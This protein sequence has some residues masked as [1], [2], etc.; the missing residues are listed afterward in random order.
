MRGRENPRRFESLEQEIGN[1]PVS[2][3]DPFSFLLVLLFVEAENR[4]YVY[5]RVKYTYKHLHSH[6][7]VIYMP[8]CVFVCVCAWT[9]VI[10]EKKVLR[11]RVTAPKQARRLLQ[12]AWTQ[13]RI[14]G[15]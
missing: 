10:D 2:L 15:I 4:S 9:S 3:L 12:T 14:I 11:P 1:S 5:K 6:A 7:D 8:V 13:E